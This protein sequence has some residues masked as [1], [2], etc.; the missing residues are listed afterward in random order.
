M[1]LVLLGAAP[2]TVRGVGTEG[3][4]VGPARGPAGWASGLGARPAAGRRQGRGRVA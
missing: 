3:A 4:Q 2:L 1:L